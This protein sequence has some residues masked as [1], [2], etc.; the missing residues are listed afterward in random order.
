[1]KYTVNDLNDI[2]ELVIFSKSSL[3]NFYFETFVGDLNVELTPD[4]NLYMQFELIHSTQIVEPHCTL[5]D[6]SSTD[7]SVEP[8]NPDLLSLYFDSSRSKDGAV[9][10]CLLIDPH[11]N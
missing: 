7:Y 9:V 2:N 10:A 1:M 3:G 5:I 8:T 11:G 6:I 4:V